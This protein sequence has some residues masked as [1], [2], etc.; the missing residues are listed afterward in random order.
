MPSFLTQCP[1]CLTPFRVTETQLEAADGLV[2][3]GACLGIFSAAANRIT[4]KQTPEEA[5]ATG[6]Q[7]PDD[8]MDSEDDFEKPWE[9]IP[10]SDDLGVVDVEEVPGQASPA[11]EFVAETAPQEPAPVSPPLVFDVDVDVRVPPPLDPDLMDQGIE[12]SLGDFNLDSEE[13]EDNTAEYENET[14]D[15]DEEDDLEDDEEF[16]DEDEDEEEYADE[17]EEGDEDEETP[18]PLAPRAPVERITTDKTELRR[19]LAKIEDDDALEPLDDDA[20]D[21]FD[22]PVT[23]VAAPRRSR[24]VGVALFLGCVLLAGL[25]VLQYT[26]ANLETLSRSA[27]FAPLMPYACRVLDCP[28]QERSQ[29][30]MLVTEQLVVRSHPRYAQALEV[31]LVFRN[32]ATEAQPF[33]ALELGFSDTGGRLLANRVF[34]PAEYLPSEL[35]TSEMPPQSSFQATLEMADPGS[36]AVNYTLVFRAP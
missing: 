17:F 5:A 20:L 35:Q 13:P 36:E 1:H 11:E 31:N 23:F 32:D 4:L 25:L 6:S 24:L 26:S 30:S 12:I 3:C 28:A 15:D 7:E 27:R 16:E 22:D 10:E 18:P 29:L 2:R 19:Y 21:D 9:Q 14:F 34:Q 8:E 33:P